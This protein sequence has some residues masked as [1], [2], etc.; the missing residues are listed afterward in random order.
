M[1]KAAFNRGRLFTRKLHL[2][3]GKKLVELYISGMALYG[4]ETWHF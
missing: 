1:T 4:A 3:I 2:N